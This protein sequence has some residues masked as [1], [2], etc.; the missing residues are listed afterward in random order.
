[1]HRYALTHLSDAA[2]LRAL[3]RL[4]AQDRW[5]MA[6][7]L[8]HIGEVDARRL[9]APAGYSCMHA[10][11]VGELRLSDDA[12]ARR[13]QA[14]RAA[15]RTPAVLEAVAE[16]RLHLTA[17]CLL[18]PYLTQENAEELIE[19]ATHRRKTEIEMV[20]LRRL[21]P[22]GVAQHAPAHVGGGGLGPGGDVDEH[23]L[24]HVEGGGSGSGG[25]SAE[26]ALAHVGGVGL[27]SVSPS[28]ERVSLRMTISINTQEKLRYAQALLSHA[29]PDGDPAE[30]LDRALD[31]L[32]RELERRKFG[33][34][35]A[36]ARAA[37]ARGADRRDS[38]TAAPAERSAAR[39][40]YIP[41][42]V[43]RTVW[44]RDGGRCTFESAAGH[45][46]DA[47]RFLEFDHVEPLA[48]GGRATVDGLRLRCR[49]HNQYEAERIFGMGFM[50][51]RRREARLARDEAQE[52]AR[53][54]ARTRAG[55]G[56]RNQ[57]RAD[58]QI[59]EIQSCLRNLGCR[60]EDAR[61]AAEHAATAVG[62][63]AGLEE[64][65]RVALR[66]VARKSVATV[67]PA[68]RPPAPAPQSPAPAHGSPAERSYEPPM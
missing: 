32:I 16:G 10:Y 2:L 33:A 38:T 6:E 39:P 43:R 30:V 5:T 9:Y 46:C 28:P 60:A 59:R 29:V 8:A 23:A 40:R 4:I 12:A 13:I 31:V 15:R 26:H 57:A 14:A 58:G 48:R 65:I 50:S 64:R 63:G 37:K 1:M 27:G 11:C 42:A 44:E 51:E 20:L 45:R 61:R 21:S 22:G 35:S 24:A 34:R 67:I 68:P 62:D 53:I 54:G 17:V 36:R 19:A 49:A 3:A 52:Q 7:I 25:E 55:S 56:A 18:A 41:A 66:A 47:R